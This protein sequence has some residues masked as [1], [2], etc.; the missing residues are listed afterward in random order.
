MVTKDKE[1]HYIFI[2]ETVQQ[3]YTAIV[4]TYAIKME[5]PKYTKQQITNVKK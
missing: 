2:K 3:E 1:G 4:N 5:A